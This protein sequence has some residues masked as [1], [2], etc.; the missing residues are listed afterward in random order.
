MATNKNT[1]YVTSLVDFIKDTKPYHC[2]LSEIV[3]EYHFSDNLNVRIRD[4]M[5]TKIKFDSTWPYSFNS[6]GDTINRAF[7][8]QRVVSPAFSKFS[9]N[10][11]VEN[12]GSYR[13]YRDENGDL[14]N[15]PKAILDMGLEPKQTIFA[16]SKEAFDGVG[17]NDAFVE[18]DGDPVR[19]EPLLEGHDFFQSH[20]AFTLRIKQT[21]NANGDFVPQYTSLN[22]EGVIAE[23]TRTIQE[24]ALDT[25]NP[26][27]AVNKIKAILNGVKSSFTDA[28]AKAELD[29]LFETLS[30][31]ELPRS[32][33]AF[34]R[35]T[36]ERNVLSSTAA[37]ALAV[38]IGAASPSLYFNAYTDLGARSDGRL[39][40]DN[41]RNNT[42]NISDIII[43]PDV[44]VFEEWILTCIAITDDNKFYFSVIGSHSG[45]IGTVIAGEQFA[46]LKISFTTKIVSTPYIGQQINL[47]PRN[48]LVIDKD[49]PLETWNLIKVNPQAYTRPVFVSTRFG[50]LIND[51]GEVG[52][53]TILD[54]TMG[55]CTYVLIAETKTKFI[56]TKEED[57]L[58]SEVVMVGVPFSDGK[59]SFTIIAG[60]DHPFNVGESF[61]L[62]IT[63]IPAWIED[64]RLGYGYD[65]D[66]FDDQTLPYDSLAAPQ[67][68]L[69]FFY[70][71]RYP[72]YNVDMIGLKVQEN[73]V[74]G[75][76]W[77]MV[78][79]PGDV[80][81]TDVDTF[82]Y[83]PGPRP[84]PL[85][86]YYAKGF[87]LQYSDDDFLTIVDLTPSGGLQ[88]DVPYSSEVHGISFTIRAG[89]KPFIGAISDFPGFKKVVGGDMFS[90]T[91]R[92]PPPEVDGGGLN[93][94]NVPRLIMHGDSYHFTRESQW[95]V[96]II[97][98]THYKVSEDNK[99][100]DRV[101]ESKNV[102]M[103]FKDLDIHF[104]I[105]GGKWGLKSGEKFTFKTFDKKPSYLVHGSV[106]GWQESA[107]VGTYYSNGKISF[108][109]D[110]PTPVLY[111]LVGT[112]IVV[113]TQRPFN[114]AVNKKKITMSRLRFDT[115]SI[116]YLLERQDFGYMVT[117]SDI[118]VIGFAKF[119]EIFTDEYIRLR[120]EDTRMEALKIDINGSQFPLWNG[121][122]LLIVRPRARF[123]YPAP[124]DF[125][126]VEK[127]RS[128]FAQI[129][130][131]SS[132]AK[133][134]DLQN[135][136]LRSIDSSFIPTLPELE[137]TS[138]ETKVRN[139]W[140]PTFF[141]REDVVNSPAH[142]SD[143]TVF[144]HAHSAATGERIGVLKP[145]TTN[146][147]EP[148]VFEWDEQF[149]QKYLPPNAETTLVTT[150]TGWSEKVV[151][152][153][154]ESIRFLM[155]VSNTPQGN[156]FFD[157]I[158]V[159]VTDEPPTTVDEVSALIK[160]T[161]N[162]SEQIGVNIIDSQILENINNNTAESETQFEEVTV[163]LN[164]GPGI[165][166]DSAAYDR[167]GYDESAEEKVTFITRQYRPIDISSLSGLAYEEYIT[168]YFIFGP[169]R[170]IEVTFV[171]IPD[172]I[173]VFYLW[174]QGEPIPRR[175][176]VVDRLSQATFALYIAN[177][178]RG[179]VIIT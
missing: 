131:T 58:Y 137:F 7:L 24:L 64:L 119:G 149:L 76:K 176:K 82:D 6:S 54:P 47:V 157:H 125:V 122:D 44:A 65:L 16:Y 146:L 112:P 74:D 140:I 104:T 55:E 85:E 15:T 151:V 91:V 3:E 1:Q 148:V 45:R 66:S 95:V 72:F 130:L 78:A 34:F 84:D 29:K 117:R 32:Y 42:L 102:G 41:L 134:D 136:V 123:K 49:A 178:S 26:N 156:L 36:I 22:E 50:H 97:T 145:V 103:S 150:G 116:S 100:D 71:T 96:D 174:L 10:S 144:H 38:K 30:I 19:A 53:I 143:P 164:R 179:K 81:I 87:T 80:H 75:R 128:G 56:L 107:E 73:A 110:V 163:L 57:P 159:V 167:G 153:M 68:P 77:R 63:N 89:D 132:S 31:P 109:V 13:A 154:T 115:P 101:V 172:V 169:A 12:I 25:T 177:A 105:V 35:A 17:I 168:D 9:K 20:G 23:S 51:K 48:K 69:G 39:F 5:F 90:F 60:T 33:D 86:L 141:T 14:A 158:K 70:D 40:Y 52:Q 160:I 98:P 8:A 135:L 79:I 152:N 114:W 113:P 120:A 129:A 138:P 67:I 59:I 161:S 171:E 18:R 88:V 94:K 108:K 106:S 162:Y 173:P 4:S 62:S 111:T 165:G 83:P 118:G 175:I 37:D 11:D 142:F 127:T 93:S 170:V 155:K 139:G 99:Y 92:N 133:T 28:A 61:I 166:Y 46:H 27:S 124:S 21:Y 43:D 126:L 2:K 121:H 147:D